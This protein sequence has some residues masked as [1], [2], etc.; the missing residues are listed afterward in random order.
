MGRLSQEHWQGRW[1]TDYTGADGERDGYRDYTGAVP[2]LTTTLTPLADK[3]PHGPVWWRYGHDAVETLDQALD[4][5]DDHRAYRIRD[6]QRR[7]ARQAA[8]E[9]RRRQWEEERRAREASKWPCPS[10]ATTST[11]TRRPAWRRAAASASL[12]AAAARLAQEA[13]EAA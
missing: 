9:A 7:A 5:P 12:A 6:E 4:N 11:R 13:Q 1:T 8:E 3:G 2:V 10:C